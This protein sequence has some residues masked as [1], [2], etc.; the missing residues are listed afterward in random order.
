MNNNS[1]I[2]S[3]TMSISNSEK[4]QFDIA[5]N[6]TV[7]E[8]KEIV[9]KF[10][11]FIE[12]LQ[13]NENSNLN[14][15][16]ESE[17]KTLL[18]N[19]PDQYPIRGDSNLNSDLESDLESETETLLEDIP[20]PYPIRGD[21]MSFTNIDDNNNYNSLETAWG[22]FSSVLVKSSKPNGSN[23]QNYRIVFPPADNIFGQLE[24][25]SGIV[26]EVL[27]GHGHPVCSCPAYYY[28]RNGKQ[29]CKHIIKVLNCLGINPDRIN[30]NDHLDNLP[31]CLKQQRLPEYQWIP[32]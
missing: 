4:A 7:D 13:Q 12:R 18:E 24:T 6:F 1:N 14:S 15:A 20:D 16:S 17:T 32:E 25:D 29:I 2:T 5:G 19:I 30:W 10:G 9:N 31:F 23:L 11:D 26:P 22:T 8:A 3:L 28:N 27:K 21:S